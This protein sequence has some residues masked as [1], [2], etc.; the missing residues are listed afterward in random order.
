MRFII[1]FL[2]LKPIF[3]LFSGIL[4][5]F[6]LFLRPS[7]GCE[8]EFHFAGFHEFLAAGVDG[9]SRGA[10]VVY[11]EKMFARQVCDGVLSAFLIVIVCSKPECMFHILL[12]LPFVL[13]GL[14][15]G[16][17]FPSYRIGDDGQQGLSPDAFGY[18]FTLII[19]TFFLPFWCQG[20]GDDGVN[21]FKEISLDSFIAYH[22][23]QEEASVRSVSIFQGIDG[24]AGR[25]MALVIKQGG[26]SLDGNM[27]PE[28]LDHLV[29]VWIFPGI[30]TRQSREAGCAE[31]FFRPMKASTTHQTVAGKDQV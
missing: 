19:A 2:Y 27:C 31:H 28:Y 20:N 15:F 10:D 13:V 24:L 1:Y 25:R 30:C 22:F 3:L 17:D 18:L 4:Q 11:D 16:E 9:G 8:A 12:S 6:F 26:A 29:L 14:T 5:F 23:S 21:S 7:Y